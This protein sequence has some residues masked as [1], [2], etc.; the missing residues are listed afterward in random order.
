MCHHL[1]P[2]PTLEERRFR[3][4]NIASP[5]KSSGKADNHVIL[6]SGVSVM[7]RRQVRSDYGRAV[8]IVQMLKGFKQERVANSLRMILAKAYL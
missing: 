5:Q 6:P 3:A 2:L 8:A 4:E 7:L 1:Y